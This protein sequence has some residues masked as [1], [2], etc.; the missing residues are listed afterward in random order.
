MKVPIILGLLLSIQ[1]I[2]AKPIQIDHYQLKNGLKVLMVE[3]KGTPLINIQLG[4][5]IGSF[6]ESKG[7]KGMAHLFEHMMFRGSKN[8]KDQEHSQLIEE[9]GGYTN[10]YTSDDRTVY[11]ETIPKEK[12]EL[13]LKLESDRMNNLIINQEK[14]ETEKKV[15]LE[16]YRWRYEN[17]PQGA[18]FKK[19][20]KYL[21]KNHPYEFGAIG[22]KEDIKNFTTEQSMSFYKKYYAP[23]NATL[24]IVGDI[25]TKETIPIIK[26]YFGQ[27][28]SSKQPPYPS[29]II[30]NETP[31]NIQDT[32]KLPFPLT[33]VT[34]YLPPANHK[35]SLALSV[36][37]NILDRDET[38]RLSKEIIKKKE[39]ASHFLSY[40]MF[41]K[42]TGCFALTA[43]HMPGL[44]KKIKNTIFE[45]IDN[46]IQNGVTQKE[47]TKTINQI[48]MDKQ[49]KKYKAQSI[50][51]EVL[52]NQMILNDP[53]FTNTELEK[54]KKITNQEIMQVAKKY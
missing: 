23:N 50:A 54:I 43:I 3:K 27:F 25:N 8:V 11:Y 14:L 10:A 7:E 5:N 53:E 12:L 9:N 21:Y 49:L 42:G 47:L 44:S 24:I 6:V 28:P 34:Y 41:N 20:L 1:I 36:L 51:S 17:N 39:I 48:T 29:L 40:P 31:I 33:I 38:S 46:I 13:I 16:E 26:K 30:K 2:H 32:S 52:Y 18:V 37:M 19:L 15:V 22:K 45:Q 4:Y 35:D